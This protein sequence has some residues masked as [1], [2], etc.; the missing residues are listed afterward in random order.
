V[1]LSFSFVVAVLLTFLIIAQQD[2]I[3]LS[4]TYL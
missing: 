3:Y 4:K 1:S 2:D